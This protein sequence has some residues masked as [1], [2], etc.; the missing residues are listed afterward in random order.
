MSKYS[1]Y[2]RRPKT[3]AERRASYAADVKIRPRRY[4]HNLPDA[5]D[6]KPRQFW[7]SWKQ[8]RK[9]QWKPQSLDV[10]DLDE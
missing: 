8:Y 1:S 3:T 9:Q 6:D 5:W 7:R 2:L 10:E 4:G